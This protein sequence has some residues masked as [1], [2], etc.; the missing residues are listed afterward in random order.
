MTW[1][2]TMPDHQPGIY[3]LELLVQVRDDSSVVQSRRQVSVVGKLDVLAAVNLAD[4]A[5]TMIDNAMADLY[6]LSR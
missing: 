5:Q 6:D 1:T 4:T 3:T 2:P